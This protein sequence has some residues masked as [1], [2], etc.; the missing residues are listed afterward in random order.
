MQRKIIQIATAMTSFALR[1]I[2]TGSP[3]EDDDNA[4]FCH[5][6]MAL[7]N[8]GSLWEWICSDTRGDRWEKIPPIPQQDQEISIKN[9]PKK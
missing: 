3:C 7:C 5:S 8:D 2:V 6:T 4:G 1:A 9:I